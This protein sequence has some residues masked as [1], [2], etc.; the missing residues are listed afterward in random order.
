VITAGLE[1][2]AKRKRLPADMIAEARQELFQLREGILKLMDD[3]R[4]RE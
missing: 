3:F 2:V 4:G 1:Q